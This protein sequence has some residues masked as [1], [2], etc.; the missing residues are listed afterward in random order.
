MDANDFQTAA[1]LA[2]AAFPDGAW[3]M[4]SPAQRAAAIY[5]ELRKL[6]AVRSDPVA[7]STGC[8]QEEAPSTTGRVVP[9]RNR[10]P[11]Y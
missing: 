9:F 2:E 4:M 3:F 5:H 7:R 11:Q 8:K 1:K 6:D 10:D